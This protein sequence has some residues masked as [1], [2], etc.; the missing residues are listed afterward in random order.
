MYCVDRLSMEVQATDIGTLGDMQD[1]VALEATDSMEMGTL[2]GRI[3][4]LVLGWVKL[5][6][7][8]EVAELQVESEIEAVEEPDAQWGRTKSL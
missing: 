2:V 1:I 7:E 6:G 5:Q 4:S 3:D 8:V